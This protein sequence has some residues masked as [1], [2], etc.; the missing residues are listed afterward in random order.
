MC[1]VFGISRYKSVDFVRNRD[2]YSDKKQCRTDM[3]LH[4]ACLKDIESYAHGLE[5]LLHLIFFV[6]SAHDS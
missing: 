2:K 5:V 6:A 3:L 4:A 1:L